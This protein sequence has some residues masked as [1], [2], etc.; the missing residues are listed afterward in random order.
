MRSAAALS[1][2]AYSRSEKQPVNTAEHSS[3]GDLE[4]TSYSVPLEEPK[5]D[6]HEETDVFGHDGDVNFR[7]MEW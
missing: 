7:T 5:Q 3:K 1:D 2:D 4:V 6:D